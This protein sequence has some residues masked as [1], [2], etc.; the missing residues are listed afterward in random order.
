M[1]THGSSHHSSPNFQRFRLLMP[2]IVMALLLTALFGSTRVWPAALAAESVTESVAESVTESAS[3][4]VQFNDAAQAVRFITFTGVISGFTALERS[5][6]DVVSISTDF[7]P[8]ICSIEGVGCPAEDCFCDS[9]RF[10]NYSYWDGA[11]WQSYPVGAGSSVISATGAIE[12]WRWGEWGVSQIAP[13]AALAAG[14]ALTWLQAQDAAVNGDSAGVS[15]AAETLL[16]LGSNHQSLPSLVAFLQSNGVTATLTSP[17]AAGKLAT[18]LAA[19]EACYPLTAIAP[20]GHYSPTLGAYSPQIGPNSWAMLGA[21]AF[22]VTVPS[23][24]IDYIK[25]Q[26]L[27]NG[28]WEWAPGW[29]ADS[30]T[31][32]LA[33]QALIAAGEPT[34]STVITNAL[35]FLHTVQRDSGGFAYD[36]SAGNIA[37]AN[38]TAYA[39][40]AL[41][42]AGEDPTGPAWTVN[43]KTPIGYL[44]AMQLTNGS[45]EWQPGNGSNLLATQQAIPALLG[46]AYPPAG[47]VLARCPALHLP[48]LLR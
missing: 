27:A 34:N 11:Q 38:S 19:A 24:A 31:T 3:V 18:A 15:G 5:G 48:L 29:G 41:V 7:G 12:G 2:V 28:G 16:A 42:A 32:A 23:T 37:D 35:D 21:A 40:Q 1:A 36:A 43:G 26:A 14:K 25:D 20:Q 44:L 30:N 13:D 47:H 45:L 46:R 6:L 8:A 33:I 39:V 9:Q 10:W 22:S 17:S 4:I